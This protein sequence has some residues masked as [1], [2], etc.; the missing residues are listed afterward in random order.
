MKLSDFDYEL[1]KELIAQ[2]ASIPKDS[3]KLMIVR[4]DS[5]EHKKFSDV[6]N[7][8]E[9]GDVLVINEA[10]VSRAKLRGRKESGGKAEV[11]LCKRLGKDLFK[12]RIKGS[13]LREG[14]IIKFKQGL[15]SKIV[16]KNDDVF[17]IKFNKPIS[18]NLK[19]LFELPLPPYVKEPLKDESEYQTVYSKKEGSLAAPTAGLHFTDEL[20]KRIKEKGVKIAKICLHIDFGTFLP[21]RGKIKDHKMHEECFEISKR[22]AEIINNRKGRLIVVG[23][24]CVRALESSADEKGNIIPQK[25]KTSLFIYPGYRFKT[26]I[27]AIITNFHLPKSTLLLLV[28][29]YFGRERI[30]EAYKL[31]VEKKY[32]FY[33][34]GDAMILIS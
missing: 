34:L 33:S 18:E 11:I 24:T 27:D 6:I 13:R 5:V 19:R 17:T 25:S 26:R 29:A 32:R 7:Y 12:C 4:K 2:H 30:L 14:I 16:K 8:L 15:S 31:A 28:S 20:L 9:K 22:N 23:T 1:P 3:S 10:K 21:I